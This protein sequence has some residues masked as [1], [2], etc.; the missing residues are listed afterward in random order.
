MILL[1]LPLPLLLL[2]FFFLLLLV[3]SCRS[4]LEQL[5]LDWRLGISYKNVLFLHSFR[6][7]HSVYSHITIIWVFVRSFV[8]FYPFYFH[9]FALM[10]RRFCNC[11]Q[12]ATTFGEVRRC[13]VVRQYGMRRIEYTKVTRWRHLFRICQWECL[14]T[15][16]PLS[17]VC[18]T[19]RNNRRGKEI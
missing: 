10:R 8:G 18:E 1:P 15:N 11:V 19:E 4:R 6:S 12:S 17:I 13:D 3:C 2:I 7:F 5:K 14:R 9:V 16:Y